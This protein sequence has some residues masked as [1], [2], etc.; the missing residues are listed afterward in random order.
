MNI[1]STKLKFSLPVGTFDATFDRTRMTIAR[2]TTP[3]GLS[4]L[5]YGSTSSQRVFGIPVLLNP[6]TVMNI[7]Q[8]KISSEYDTC[9]FTNNHLA[10]Q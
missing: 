7:P 1:Y 9:K 3:F 4:I 6:S 5:A 2:R 8:K 10:K